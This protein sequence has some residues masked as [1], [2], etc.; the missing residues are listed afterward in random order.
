MLLI[1]TGVFRAFYSEG[2]F[3]GAGAFLAIFAHFGQIL[4]TPLFCALFCTSF[5][6]CLSIMGLGFPTDVLPLQSRK[7]VWNIFCTF[8]HFMKIFSGLLGDATFRGIFCIHYHFVREK[9]FCGVLPLSYIFIPSKCR[10]W[11]V[12]HFVNRIC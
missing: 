11:V 6:R 5:C 4:F 8:R 1:P 12:Q 3:S 9:P 7:T 2:S 10:T